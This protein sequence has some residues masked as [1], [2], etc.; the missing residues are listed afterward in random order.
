MTRLTVAV[1]TPARLATSAMVA[2]ARVLGL[3]RELTFPQNG[4][5]CNRLHYTP[6]GTALST[7]ARRVPIRRG[8]PFIDAPIIQFLFSRQGQMR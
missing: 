8:R 4:V 6:E 3:R 1:E 7:S 5:L 2:L